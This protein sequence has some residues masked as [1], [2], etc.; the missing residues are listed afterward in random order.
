VISSGRD[1]YLISPKDVGALTASLR[2]L[3][4]DGRKLLNMSLA[5]RDRITRHPTWEQTGATIREFLLTFPG[6]TSF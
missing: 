3:L 4:R 5:A 6:R 2:E 1:G